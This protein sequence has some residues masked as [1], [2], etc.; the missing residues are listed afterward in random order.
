MGVYD[1]TGDVADVFIA[2]ACVILPLWRW[3]A[4]FRKAERRTIL[5]EE[6]L[7]L[8]TKPGIRVVKD[9]GAGIRRMRSAVGM[10]DLT[11]NKQSVGFRRIR[12]GSHRLEHA[13]RAVPLGLPR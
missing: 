11:K 8:K 13:I 10:K 7:L 9:R 5:P 6:I 12:I 4:L 3:V 2:D 1:F